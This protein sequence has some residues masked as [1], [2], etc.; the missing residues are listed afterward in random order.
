MRE[1][2]DY[3]VSDFAMDS[4]DTKGLVCRFFVIPM[5]NEALSQEAGRPIF[6][7]KEYI[8]YH[9]IGDRSTVIAEEVNENHKFRWGKQYAQYRRYGVDAP[10]TGTPLG[11]VPWMSKSQIE[12]FKYL[13][14]LSIEDLANV[15]DSVCTKVSGLFALKARA[16]AWIEEAKG[17]AGNAALAKQIEE[18]QR[19][20][21]GMIAA[22]TSLENTKEASKQAKG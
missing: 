15:S 7:D 11:E 10:T 16:I 9:G 4:D 22:Q 2:A 3:D 13:K 6:E 8:E 12:E 19:Q 1:E 14:I 17:G 20:M 21:A 18:L 5:Q